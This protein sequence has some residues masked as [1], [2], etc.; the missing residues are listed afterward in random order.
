[1]EPVT[2]IAFGLGVFVGF[3]ACAW[4]LSSYAWRDEERR[5]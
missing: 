1:M 3:I 2:F 5:Q 4:A